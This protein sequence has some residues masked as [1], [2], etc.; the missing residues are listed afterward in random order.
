MIGEDTQVLDYTTPE[1]FTP[2]HASDES[3]KLQ[4]CTMPPEFEQS[5][6]SVF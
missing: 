1:S 2:T 3:F 5:R 4:Y 6:E